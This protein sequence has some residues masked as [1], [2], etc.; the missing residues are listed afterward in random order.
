MPTGAENLKRY[1]PTPK[2]IGTVY[3]RENLRIIEMTLR[4]GASFEQVLELIMS[5]DDRPEK[6]TV[7]TLK[8]YFYRCGGRITES[9]TAN[10]PS[11]V[12]ALPIPKR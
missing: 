11:S 10:H 5:G 7:E 8:T 12:V 9:P 2:A 3:V 4:S 6:M 1:Q